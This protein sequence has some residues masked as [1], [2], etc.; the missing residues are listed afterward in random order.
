MKNNPNMLTHR[1]EMNFHEKD[2]MTAF[3]QKNCY[4]GEC[5]NE[6][7]FPSY[8]IVEVMLV[9]IKLPCVTI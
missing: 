3:I 5:E 7:R 9:K 1:I 8:V 4:H 2:K 6:F